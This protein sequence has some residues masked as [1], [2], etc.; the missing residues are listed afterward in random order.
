MKDPRRSFRRYDEEGRQLAS[1][2]YHLWRELAEKRGNPY[3]DHEYGLRAG[4]L[5]VDAT[6]W[7]DGLV[8]LEAIRKHMDEKSS[9]IRIPEWARLEGSDRREAARNEERQREREQHDRAVEEM[10]PDVRRALIAVARA[11]GRGRSHEDATADVSCI[12]C[13]QLT[14]EKCSSCSRALHPR[15]CKSRHECQP[16]H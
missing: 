11:R 4:R 9:P 1:E 15:G 7:E 13:G 14:A 2:A 16:M 12:V 10:D 5:A 6:R 3:S 8:I